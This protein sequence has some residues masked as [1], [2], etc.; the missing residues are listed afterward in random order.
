MESRH[1]PSK[2]QLVVKLWHFWPPTFQTVRE[3]EESAFTD[4]PTN[5]PKP[6]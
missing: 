4:I 2:L 3:K 1:L 6:M 5:S